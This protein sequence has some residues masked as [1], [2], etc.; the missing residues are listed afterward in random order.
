MHGGSGG[1]RCSLV[2]FYD[3]RGSL[4]G[5][6]LFRWFKTAVLPIH[7]LPLSYTCVFFFFFSP[8][9]FLQAPEHRRSGAVYSTRASKSNNHRPLTQWSPCIPTT[10]RGSQTAASS[11]PSPAFC[12]QHRSGSLRRAATSP[13]TSGSM[14][15][16][17]SSPVR[18][19][20]GPGATTEAPSRP[21]ARRTSMACYT[22]V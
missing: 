20:T 4:T 5:R 16:T 12:E 2:L 8:I 10:P 22:P 18:G 15:R 19:I 13:A 7:G 17:K 14:K 21:P 1:A 11:S 9:Q 3:W 6:I